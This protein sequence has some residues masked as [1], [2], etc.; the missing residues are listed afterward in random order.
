M[1]IELSNGEHSNDEL[2]DGELSYIE[3]S[4]ESHEAGFTLSLSI[5]WNGRDEPSECIA[6]VI[7]AFT[8]FT[9]SQVLLVHV[10]GAPDGTP[11]SMIL[12]TYDPRF[13][14]EHEKP[15]KRSWIPARPW[16]LEKESAA[17]ERRAAVTRGEH[18]GYYNGRDAGGVYAVG[19]VAR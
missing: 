17:A 6:T 13:F 16:S 12:K 8:P 11:P 1:D 10:H 19:E 9:K 4:D 3:S 2:S 5:T 15:S 7:K 18:E 14:D